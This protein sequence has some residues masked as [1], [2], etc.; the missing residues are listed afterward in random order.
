MPDRQPVGLPDT[1]YAVNALQRDEIAAPLEPRELDAR[2][3]ALFRR[4][5]NDLNEGGS[6]TLFLAV[7]FLR[8]KKSPDEETSYR[9]PLLLVPIK[10]ERRSAS[11]RF[12]L[13]HHEDDVRFN[14]TLLQML[15]K[16]FDLSLT[17]FEGELPRDDSGIDVPLIL[18]TMRR[19]VRDVPGF[20]VVGET[21]LSTFSFA[22]YLMWKDLVDRTE[23]LR[24]NRVVRHLVDSPQTPFEPGV[25]TEGHDFVLVGPP[26]GGF[27]SSAR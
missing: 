11:S 2:L 20:E 9:A 4:A 22:K 27:E 25:S 7:G 8:W 17:Q 5:R 21:A 16:D 3:T 6:N 13:L 15:E 18:E 1:E 12:Y 14:A 23:A 24:N 10:L 26:G 19:A